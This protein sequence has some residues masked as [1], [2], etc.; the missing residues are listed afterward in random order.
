M[1]GSHTPT[2]KP[3]PGLARPRA[4]RS[5]LRLAFTTLVASV[6]L[7]GAACSVGGAGT[8]SSPEPGAMGVRGSS[9]PSGFPIDLPGGGTVRTVRSNEQGVAVLVDYPSGFD[10]I[11]AF[12]EDWMASNIDGLD[13]TIES[14]SPRQVSWGMRDG[15][16][17]YLIRIVEGADGSVQVVVN[18]S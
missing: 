17:I 12:F 8:G 11:V 6:L 14:A 1:D 7:L 16:A 9:L 3:S 15:E 10:D 13:S 5:R 18:L 2:G 4:R